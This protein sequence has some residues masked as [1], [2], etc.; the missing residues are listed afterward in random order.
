VTYLQKGRL[1]QSL[2]D[3]N[4]AIRLDQN[5]VSAFLNRG[6]VYAA[7]GDRD[8][9]VVEFECAT[10]L[11]PKSVQGWCLLGAIYG[12]NGDVARAN[13]SVEAAK[14]IDVDYAQRILSTI[15]TI[16][17]QKWPAVMI[18]EESAKLATILKTLSSIR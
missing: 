12:E 13:N 5:A 17:S 6:L 11:D 3:F 2:E 15:E 16:S 18:A 1:D 7:K 4:A 9:A 10:T 14:N 8:S